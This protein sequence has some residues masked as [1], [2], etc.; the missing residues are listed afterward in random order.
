M[1]SPGE[2][3][4]PNLKSDLV[5]GKSGDKI[6]YEIWDIHDDASLTVEVF[7]K[8]DHELVI[9]N[10]KLGNSTKSTTNYL[11]FQNVLVSPFTFVDVILHP[12]CTFFNLLCEQHFLNSARNLSN[13]N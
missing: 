7:G 11:H 12:L 5:T 4:G 9:S 10:S 6:E 3:F 1:I 8:E 2:A 13:L